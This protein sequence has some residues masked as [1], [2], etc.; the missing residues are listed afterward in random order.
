MGCTYYI[1]SLFPTDDCPEDA[2]FPHD[3]KRKCCDAIVRHSKCPNGPG[4][5]LETDPPQCCNHAATCSTTVCNRP[6]N[7]TCNGFKIEF[8]GIPIQYK[9]FAVDGGWSE[10]FPTA[11]IK[12][13][14]CVWGVRN[15]TRLCNRPPPSGAGK[16][17]KGEDTTMQVCIEGWCGSLGETSRFTGRTGES[18]K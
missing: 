17:C 1:R 13:E 3:N 16:P 4:L 18:A 15:Y 11:C 14:L 8:F 7:V 9:L 6:S 12:K 5:L 10:W 2:P